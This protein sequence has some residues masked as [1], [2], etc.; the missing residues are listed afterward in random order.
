MQ[1]AAASETWLLTSAKV[2]GHPAVASRFL[3]RLEALLG[4][5]G[6][7][8]SLRPEEDWIGYAIG[9]DFAPEHRPVAQP[10]P[11]PPV[12]LRPSRLSVT[13]IDKLISDP[14]TI[15]A[16]QILKLEELAPL[17]QEAG[18]AERGTLLHDALRRFSEGPPALSPEAAAKKLMAIVDELIAGADI[19]IAQAAFWRQEMR[20]I[21][22]WF[23]TEDAKLRLDTGALYAEVRGAIDLPLG[24]GS[25]LPLRPCR[26]HRPQ[27]RRNLAPHRLQDRCAPSF[28]DTA[29][30]LAA[31]PARSRHCR[32]R[33]LREPLPG[34][35]HELVYFHLTGRDPAGECRSLSARLRDHL[36]G[37]EAGV[38]RLL[39]A[40]HNE[41][42]AYYPHVPDNHRRHDRYGH[43][44]R[45]RE[46]IHASLDKVGTGE[47]RQ[48]LIRRT[49]PGAT[50]GAPPI[51]RSRPSSRPMPDRER[52]MC[53]SPAWSA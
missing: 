20:R 3:L 32:T 25:L 37:A 26:S 16:E 19:G 18:A 11:R 53:W 22:E 2:G 45:W 6:L 23:A 52:P 33:R 10:A 14:Y 36:D 42:Q 29:A 12:A 41:A 40:W 46:W 21:A 5:A 50:N 7:A 44:S 15:Y 4:A 38:K 30:L 8:E 1:C 49:R 34:H 9:L 27:D 51:Q 48:W 31:A 17:W 39:T 43:L 28:D 35:R 47:G 13:R 24:D